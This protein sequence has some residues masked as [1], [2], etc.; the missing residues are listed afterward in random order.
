MTSIRLQPE[1]LEF[2]MDYGLVFQQVI[3]QIG[4]PKIPSDPKVNEKIQTIIHGGNQK[5]H[6]NFA[7][8]EARMMDREGQSV[9][10]DGIRIDSRRWCELVEHME[11]P[12]RVCGFVITLGSEVDRWIQQTQ[13]QSMFDAFIAD[14][15]GSVCIELT[16]DRLTQEIERQYNGMDLVCSKRLSPGYCDWPLDVGQKAIFKFVQTGNIGV[17]CLPNG[18]MVPLK[19]IS[20]VIFAGIS[21]LWKTPCPICNDRSCRHRREASP[22]A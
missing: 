2:R 9:V 7:F 11:S 3:L 6:V 21:T 22:E 12:K 15:F 17:S 13:T 5:I 4:Y 1:S 18:L 16:A 14:A 19:T 10:A 20:A 8:R